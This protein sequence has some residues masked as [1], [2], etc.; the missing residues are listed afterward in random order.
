MNYK[1]I[2]PC[3]VLLIFILSIF[4]IPKDVCARTRKVVVHKKEYTKTVVKLPNGHSKIVVSGNPYYFHNGISY[5]K[6]TKGYVVVKTPVGARVKSLPR[7]YTVV[8]VGGKKYYRCH[9]IYFNF[10]PIRKVYVVVGTP[11]TEFVID[12]PAVHRVQMADGSTYDGVYLGGTKEMI[13]IEV[14]EEIWEIPVE[15][16]EYISFVS[17]Q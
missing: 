11:N 5:K 7:G 17:G 9:N 12:Y 4:T 3:I 15:D 10:D 16:I 2:F 13:E 1:H 6:A 8:R 14:G